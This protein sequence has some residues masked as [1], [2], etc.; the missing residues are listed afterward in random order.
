MSHVTGLAPLALA[1]GEDRQARHGG[2]GPPSVHAGSDGDDLSTELVA[3]DRA[4]GQR[5][6]RLQVGAAQAAGRDTE[7]QFAR[8]RSRV[9]QRDDLVTAVLADYGR[10][11][12]AASAQRSPLAF[13]AS[14]IGFHCSRVVSRILMS[15][16]V[17]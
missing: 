5:A 16:L 4:R 2:S 6:S 17:A 8:A 3:H 15:K 13:T 11:H 7:Q 10:A 1:A 12:D 9:R 14:M